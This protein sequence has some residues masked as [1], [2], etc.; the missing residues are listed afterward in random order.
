MGDFLLC[1]PDGRHE[2]EL[3]YAG[4]PPH[5][6]SYHTIKIDGDTFPGFAWGCIFSISDDSRYLAFSW[7]ATYID[8]KTIV[9]D[10]ESYSYFVL[11]KYVCDVKATHHQHEAPKL[12]AGLSI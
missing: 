12:P 8:R 2:I 5:G 11:P 4:E 1:T 10:L 6:D 3:L 7:M 9:V